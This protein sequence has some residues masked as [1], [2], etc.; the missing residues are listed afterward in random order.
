MNILN[1][2]GQL[3]ELG[4]VSLLLALVLL[5]VVAFKIL[6][7]VMQTVMVSALSGAF[8]FA[9]A[10][11]LESVAFSFNSL[12][13]F[14]FIGGSLYTGYHMI[15][16]GYAILSLLLTVPYRIGKSLVSTA[17]DLGNKLEDRRKTEDKE[18]E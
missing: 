9:L 14:A 5:F 7:M 13:F 12:L 8:Y 15:A 3:G 6:E 16:Q 11:Y 2:A 17:G 1:L 10:Y 18:E 4:T